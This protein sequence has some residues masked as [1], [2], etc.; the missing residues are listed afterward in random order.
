MSKRDYYDV[1]GVSKDAS[2]QDIKKAYRKLA[3]KYHPDVSQEEDAETKFKEVQ[4][5]YDALSDEQK[6]AAYDRFGHEGAQGFGGAGGFGGFEGFGGAGGFGDI[7]DIFEQ[8]FGGGGGGGFSSGGRRGNQAAQGE[9]IRIQMTISFE[10]AAFGATKEV[11]IN[12]DEECTRCGGLG[13]KSKDDISTCNRCNGRGVINQVQQTLLGRMQTQTACPDCNGKGKVIKDKCPECRGRGINSKTAKIK[14]KIPA[15]IDDGQQIR[16][17]GKGNAGLNGGPSGDLY[18]Y[19][20]VKKH[21]FYTREGFDL[22]GEIPVTFSQ[23]TLGDEI[24]IQTLKGKVKLK[25]PAGTQPN[26]E[27]RIPNKGIKYVNR[28]SYGDLYIRVKLIVPKKVTQKQ[29]ELLQE[30][31]ELEDKSDSIWDKVRG[32]FK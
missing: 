26:T 30:F 4:E 32:I 8:F 14:I 24:E 13:A 11:S 31:S 22:H 28:E 3:R 19:F 1:L 25:V 21:K 27:F 7:G 15:G 20:N 23:A 9:S 2:G 16:I 12:R 17:R 10:E 18:V 5:A 29:Q 6:R